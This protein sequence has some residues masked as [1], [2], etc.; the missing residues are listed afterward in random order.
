M[1]TEEAILYLR[2][3]PAYREL[4]RDAYL[5]EDGGRSAERF[6][7]S[8]EFAEARRLL[9]TAG[10][11]I[12][13]DLGAGTGIATYALARAGAQQLF[14]LEPDLSGIAGSGAIRRLTAGLPVATIAAYGEDI[15]LPDHSVDAV[16]ARQ[17]L[18]HTRDLNRV[19]AECGR[20]LRPGGVFLACR[21]HVVDD[22]A[23]L[24]HFLS[25]HPLHR[26]TNGENAY[27][28]SLYLAAIER[29][30]LKV[31][32]LLG[33]WDSVINAFPGA[34]NAA[35]LA[36][37]PTI[38]LRRRMGVIGTWAGALPFVRRLIWL[39]LKRAVPGRLYSF[40]AVKP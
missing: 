8:A 27:P 22:E 35:E 39:R 25:H 18:H 21:E 7:A 32:C 26:L 11:G 16:Y 6:L 14:A 30:E 5:D 15:P 4:L 19:L 23:Q 31:R 38:L 17:V 34:R 1:N 40:L 12:I 37:Y 13:V 10:Q 3:Q 29:A 28:L 24:A 9:G 36:D 2:R 20:I 33:P